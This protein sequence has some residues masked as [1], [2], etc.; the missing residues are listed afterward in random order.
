M[1]EERVKTI[2]V[3]QYN[4]FNRPKFEVIV[5]EVFAS[6]SEAE[7]T[8]YVDVYLTFNSTH[9]P[10]END[11]LGDVEIEVWGKR[12]LN[13][14][15]AAREKEEAEIN[16]LAKKLGITFYEANTIRNLQ[17]RGKLKGL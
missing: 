8:G 15:E 1:K 2:C 13:Q 11:A 12:P 5:K 3:N 17:S 7:E 10:Y 16:A 9:E 4:R 6:M 14:Q